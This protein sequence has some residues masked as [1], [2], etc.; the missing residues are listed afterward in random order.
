[1]HKMKVLVNKHYERNMEKSFYNS[2]IAKTLAYEEAASDVD[3]ECSFMYRHQPKSNSYDIS[4][5]LR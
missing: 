4:E 1:M 3:W 5:V 2:E